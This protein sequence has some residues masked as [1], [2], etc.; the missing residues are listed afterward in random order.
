MEIEINSSYE[1]L[2]L[3]EMLITAIDQYEMSFDT[4]SMVSGISKESLVGIY[5]GKIVKEDSDKIMHLYGI[6]LQLIE[7]LPLNHN[8]MSAI[9]ESLIDV[10]KVTYKTLSIFSDVEETKI[11][12]FYENNQDLSDKDFEKLFKGILH[13]YAALIKTDKS[14]NEMSD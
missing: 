10:L 6:F 4:I 1:E 11:K 12:S 5:E 13:V 3:T 8:Y 14:F 7:L 9:I 2:G